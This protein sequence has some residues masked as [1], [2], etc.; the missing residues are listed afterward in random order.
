MKRSSRLYMAFNYAFAVLFA[1]L[2]LLSLLRHNNPFLAM[3]APQL[4]LCGA[5]AAAA[6]Y[7]AWRWWQRRG[8]VPRHEA[9]TVRLLLAGYWLLLVGFGCL[10]Q[11]EPGGNW[12]FTVVTAAAR[13]LVLNGTPPGEYFVNCA[14]N[15]P[16]LWLYVGLFRLLHLFGIREFMP[17]LVAVNA[18][19]ITLSLWCLWRIARRLW[20]GKWALFVLVPAM[21]C[22]GLWLYTPIAY[23]D[24]LS[25]PFAC[26]A[27][28]LWLTARGAPAGRGRTLRLWGAFALAALGGILR[29]TGGILLIAFLLDLFL[30]DGW[31]R[32]RRQGVA[33]AVCG[34]LLLVG[35]S[36]AAQA[37]LPDYDQPPLPLTHWVMMGLQGDGGYNDD[38]FQLT[39]QYDTYAERQAFVRAEI[40]RRLQAMGPAGL[41][42]H[43]ARKMSYIISDG[44]CYAPS[45]LDRSV[46]TPNLLHQF[47]V[48]NAPY[49]GFLYYLADG[50]QLCLLALCAAGA[51][52]A[53]R[54][55]DA[56]T[57]ARVAV[58]GL[59]LFLLV[60]EARSRYLV[61]FLPLLLLCAASGLVPDTDRE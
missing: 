10:M 46:H 56:L 12:D 61:Q 3:G 17:W 25:M 31:Q 49:A 51:W 50:A 47:I 5:G 24:T 57:A 45:K 43:C 59:L 6:L 13:D 33:A 40:A 37:A 22:P 32:C 20:G 29:M 21:L 52:R 9:R 26:A 7:F 4:L 2:V 53:A 18:G 38:D 39:I 28:L 36:K 16:L 55:A 27:L 8:R 15:A 30:A 48:P 54:R 35:G 34:A 41:A 23:T 44:T 19:C 60:W 58:F 1:G 42:E 14:N 11:V